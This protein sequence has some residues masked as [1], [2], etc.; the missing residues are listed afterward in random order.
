MKNHSPFPMHPAAPTQYADWK[1]PAGDGELLLWPESDALLRDTEGNARRLSSAES[2]LVQGVPLPEWRRRLRQWIG[3]SDDGRPLVAAGHQTELY[4]PGVWAKNALIDAVATRVGGSAYHFAVDT[5]EPK[6][7]HLRWPG[8]GPAG[9]PLL[10]D[11]P[12]QGAQWS[13][14]LPP[15]TPAHLER[16]RRDLQSASSGWGFRPL[17]LEFLESMRRLSLEARDL[18]STLTNALHELDWGLGLR[19]H[20]LLFSPVC[21]SEPYLAFACHVLGRAGQFAADYNDSLEAYRRAHRVKAPGR[22]MPNLKLSA[23]SCE[24]PFWVDCLEKETRER[25]TVERRED[26]W[27]LVHPC[28][29]EFVFQPRAEAGALVHEFGKWLRANRLRLS[30]RA[31]T[32]TMVLRMLVAD[33]FAHGIGGA[34]YDQVADALIAKHFGL[35]PPRFCVTTATLYFPQA[36]GRPR[37]CVSCVVQEGHR[38]QHSLLGPEKERFVEAIAAAPR[39]SIERSVLFTEM[40]RRR[41]R[42]AASHPAL[43]EWEQRLREV[44][45]QHAEETE[46]FDRELF[47]AIQPAER[48]EGLVARYRAA[49]SG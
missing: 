18:P 4:H 48:L 29:S 7:L 31:L 36:V 19:H 26:A 35:E 41:Q 17:A 1:A 2:V 8:T 15:P 33:Q 23:D 11:A 34:R 5:D 40:H 37:A 14:L 44:E 24:V 13:E 3:H 39:G 27:A 22:P 46:L 49:V 21:F 47:Y 9:L 42:A 10:D 30:P 16:L 12:A 28:G 6:H 20:A 38:L 25:A 45:R 43:G 32:L